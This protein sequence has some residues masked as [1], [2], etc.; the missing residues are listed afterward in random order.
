MATNP[1]RIRPHAHEQSTAMRMMICRDDSPAHSVTTAEARRLLDHVERLHALLLLA[2]HDE[3]PRILAWREEID[4][5]GRVTD[6][7]LDAVSA[8]Y[9]VH[10]ASLTTGSSFFDFLLHPSLAELPDM[11][12]L[13][14]T[15]VRVIAR[16]LARN[17]TTAGQA[18]PD[19]RRDVVRYNEIL[20]SIQI[21][22]GRAEVG[23]I[24]DGIV[25]LVDIDREIATT[26]YIRV[27]TAALVARSPQSGKAPTQAPKLP[28]IQAIL[29]SL[30]D[31]AEDVNRSD[32]Y[33]LP[34]G[35]DG[36]ED[37]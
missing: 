33:Q 32:T 35:E 3:D 28:G 21:Q 27:L 7:I 12:R 14:L 26:E 4:A 6:A 29:D 5:E 15:P 23:R 19:D 1:D 20:N 37:E 10:V 16:S 22:H 18:V 2:R 24:L 8:C 13:L 31:T 11:L 25:R 34:P 9:P 30:A 17:Q 36:G